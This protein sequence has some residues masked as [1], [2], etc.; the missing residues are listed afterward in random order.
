MAVW[1]LWHFALWQ[2]FEGEQLQFCTFPLRLFR[3]ASAARSSVMERFKGS[4]PVFV[5]A[6]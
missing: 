5:N 1:Q 3:F 6:V 2:Q 4:L